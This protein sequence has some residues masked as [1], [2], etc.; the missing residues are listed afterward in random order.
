MER[1]AYWEFF[2]LW[3]GI[4]NIHNEI[5]GLITPAMAHGR[6]F[7]ESGN[8]SKIHLDDVTLR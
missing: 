7:A 5:I 8:V 3:P 2:H 1:P 6:F 4:P